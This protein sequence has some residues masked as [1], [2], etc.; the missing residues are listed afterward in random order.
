M[1]A[2]SIKNQTAQIFQNI[3]ILLDAVP[4]NEF[5]T[6]KGGYKTWRHFYHLIHSLDKNFIDPGSYIEPIFHKNN[7]NRI[8]IKDENVLTKNEIKEYYEYVKDKIDEY[9]KKLNDEILAEEICFNK[10]QI[11]KLEL[12]LA[13]LRHIFYHVGYLHCCIKI[14]KGGTPEYIGLY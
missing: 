2:N 13:Q 6:I 9:I 1:L 4:E 14:E 3:E 8:D 11:T 5:D 12:I 10:M 7:L